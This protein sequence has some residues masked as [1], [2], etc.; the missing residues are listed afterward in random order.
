MS[1]TPSPYWMAIAHRYIGVEE[2]PGPKAHP[3][4]VQWAKNL[5]P[6]MAS[7]FKD[8]A[9]PWCAL[10]ANGILEE[11][12]L[13]LSAKPGSYDLARAK[14][15]ETYGTPQDIPAYGSILVFNRPGGYHVGFYLGETLQRYRVLGGNQGNAFEPAWID[16]KRCIAIRWP[17][18]RV[19]PGPRVILRYDGQPSSLNET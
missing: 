8:D 4:I 1:V 9:T 5:G 17:D 6:N 14:S 19:Q 12:H 16:Q 15:F 2:V 10:A 3:T 11:A 7:L 13:P 18:P